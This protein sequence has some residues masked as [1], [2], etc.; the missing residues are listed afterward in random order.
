MMCVGQ[1]LAPEDIEV[2]MEELMEV[3]MLEVCT[4]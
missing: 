2:E 4:M 3:D 1:H